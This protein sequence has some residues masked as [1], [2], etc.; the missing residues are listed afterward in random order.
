VGVVAVKL[1]HAIARVVK[2]I[3]VQAGRRAAFG[4]GVAVPFVTLLPV[5]WSWALTSLFCGGHNCGVVASSSIPQGVRCFHNS[6]GRLVVAC[7][8]CLPHGRG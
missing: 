5:C 3:E 4:A 6:R 8:D 7:T 1:A 2:R